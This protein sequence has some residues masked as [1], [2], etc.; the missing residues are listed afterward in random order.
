MFINCPNC[1]ELIKKDLKKCPMC[2]YEITADDMITTIRESDK[3]RT[4]LEKEK[5]EE[6]GRRRVVW[7]IFSIGFVI[8]CLIITLISI[9]IGSEVMFCILFGLLLLVYIIFACVT[10]YPRCPYCNG[11]MYSRSLSSGFCPRCGGRVR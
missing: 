2:K 1:K 9:A 6:A 8:A 10:K 11:Y 4:E 3:A 7:L 5:I